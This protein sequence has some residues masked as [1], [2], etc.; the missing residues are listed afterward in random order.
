MVTA[1]GAPSSNSVTFEVCGLPVKIAD[2]VAGT[3]EVQHLKLV[4]GTDLLKKSIGF[5]LKFDGQETAPI[6]TATPNFL[7]TGSRQRSARLRPAQDEDRQLGRPVAA[8]FALWTDPRCRP[9]AAIQSALE[10]LP[11]IGAGN[12]AVSETGPGEY[13]LTFQGALARSPSGDISTGDYYSNL[14]QETLDSIVA[15]RQPLSSVPP[16]PPRRPPSPPGCRPT[17]TS[18]S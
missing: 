13:D 2:T 4:K 15:G 17:T 7:G 11:A 16:G 18:C 10:A 5:T 6:W 3:S 1:G 9:P 8:N 14:P 12:V